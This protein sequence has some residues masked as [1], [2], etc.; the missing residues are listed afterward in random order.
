M[1]KTQH[2]YAPELKMTITCRAL[3]VAG[4]LRVDA[5]CKRIKNPDARN[6]VQILETMRDGLVVPTKRSNKELMDF[7]QKYPDLTARI[8]ATITELTVK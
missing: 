5:V 8:Y 7:A 6:M 2:F 4:A 3:S 1:F